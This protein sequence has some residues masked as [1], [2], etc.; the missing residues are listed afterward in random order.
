MALKVGTT[1]SD[2]LL[3]SLQTDKTRNMTVTKKDRYK[4]KG[5]NT[6]KLELKLEEKNVLYPKSNK[7]NRSQPILHAISMMILNFKDKETING[8]FKKM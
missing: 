6:S 7:S 2:P 8:A 1:E 3:F 4:W 5:R